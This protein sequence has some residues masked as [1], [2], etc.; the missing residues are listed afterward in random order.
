MLPTN[1]LSQHTFKACGQ[2]LPAEKT[3]P[4][5]EKTQTLLFNSNSTLELSF[6]FSFTI[7][8][9]RSPLEAD[10][11]TEL[12]ETGLEPLRDKRLFTELFHSNGAFL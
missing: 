3:P 4:Y 5:S 9:H 6:A 8:V 2:P 12:I 1:V 10:Q 7:I 11:P